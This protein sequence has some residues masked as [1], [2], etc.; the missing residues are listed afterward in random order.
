LV[1][2]PSITSVSKRALVRGYVTSTDDQRPIAKIAREQLAADFGDAII[3]SDPR[4]LVNAVNAN[5]NPGIYVLLYNGLDTHNHESITFTDDE[6]VK[7]Y[8]RAIADAIATTVSQTR[9]SGFDVY[10]CISSDHG[11][12]LLPKDAIRLDPPSFIQPLDDENEEG[13]G[14]RRQSIALRSRACKITHEPDVREITQLKE[15]WYILNKAEF[16][17]TDTLLIP[18]GY[19][20]AKRRPHGW[21]HGGATPEEAV[22]PFIEVHP[23]PLQVLSPEIHFDGY[24]IPNRST[25]VSVTITNPNSFPLSNLHLSVINNKH[26]ASLSYLAATSSEKIDLTL[27]LVPKGTQIAQ[28][29]WLLRCQIIGVAY[30]FTGQVTLPIRRMQNV[31]EVDELFGGMA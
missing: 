9:R 29:D 30:E 13:I 5:N 17:L 27:S 16:G 28:L 10:A 21:L 23:L 8:L 22:V 12:T 7:G 11:S 26:I 31:S 4:E 24:L 18:R 25:T 14:E 1:A 2:L 15:N 20:Y 19:A 3:C 6:S